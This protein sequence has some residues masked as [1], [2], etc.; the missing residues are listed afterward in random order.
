MKKF[1]KNMLFKEYD[2]AIIFCVLNKV[3]YKQVVRQ[4]KQYMV[5]L[6]NKKVL[7]A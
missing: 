4:N 2:E 5:I 3:P 6:K 7:T 1:K